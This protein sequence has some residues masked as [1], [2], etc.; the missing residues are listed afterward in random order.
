MKHVK[1]VILEIWKCFQIPTSDFLWH[2]ETHKQTIA[3]DDGDD[4][5]SVDDK[6]RNVVA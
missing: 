4:D 2:T 1:Y 6:W 5:D 3:D